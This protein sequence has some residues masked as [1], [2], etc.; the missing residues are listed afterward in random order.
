VLQLVEEPLD[1]IALPIKTVIDRA[2]D[3]AIAAGRD[4]SPAAAALDPIDDGAGVIA[5]I[6]NEIA[7]RLE[8]FEQH[9]MKT[10]GVPRLE[11][12]G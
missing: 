4:M 11:F 6:G 10:I 5:T 1:Q 3:L 9:P 8:A 2:L 7:L 12:C